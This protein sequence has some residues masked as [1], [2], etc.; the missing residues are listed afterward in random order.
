MSSF[1]NAATHYVHAV[2]V[3]TDTRAMN[4]I[5]MVGR[6]LCSLAAIEMG[7]RGCQKLF[8][9]LQIGDR[10]PALDWLFKQADRGTK[11]VKVEKSE[12]NLIKKCVENSS[13]A[14]LF[15]TCAKNEIPG[16]ASLGLAYLLTYSIGIYNENEANRTNPYLICKRIQTLFN[17]I[18]RRLKR[19]PTP[20]IFYASVALSIAAC[21]K[22][23]LKGHLPM[24]S[25]L[26]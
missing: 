16:T 13:R 15:L 25:R 12:E 4:T 8:Q 23:H 18:T 11:Y 21:Y 5:P 26:L 20:P 24:L 1:V 3:Y 17:P 22:D 2:Y 14:L 19:D 7:Y 9:F 6:V 10:H